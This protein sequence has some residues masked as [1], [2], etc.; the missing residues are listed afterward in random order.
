MI[1]SQLFEPVK[2]GILMPYSPSQLSHPIVL[3]TLKDH[4]K[5]AWGTEKGMSDG[6]NHVAVKLGP[7]MSRASERRNTLLGGSENSDLTIS[8]QPDTGT[9]GLLLGCTNHTMLGS[10]FAVV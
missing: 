9:Q 10:Q 2:L 1:H 7:G 3:G 4:G 6:A 5:I 8:E